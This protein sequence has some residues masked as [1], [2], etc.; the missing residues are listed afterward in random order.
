MS[1]SISHL[2]KPLLATAAVCVTFAAHCE[3][4]QVSGPATEP[5]AGCTAKDPANASAPG[6][7]PQPGAQA[8]QCEPQA[9]TA[10]QEARAYV[11]AT[12][13]PGTTMTMQGPELAVAR[14]NPEFVTR[15]ADAIR[16]AR[17]SGLP[18]AGIFSAYRPPGF[19]IGGFLD[20]YRSLHSYGLAV[21]MTGIGDP[22]SADTKHW[23]Q[24]AARHGV[25]CPY[26]IDSKSEWNH[27]QALPGKGVPAGGPLRKTINAQGPIDLA[28]MFKVGE[29]LIDDD[30]PKAIRLAEAIN[31][32][33]EPV[34]V[35][36]NSPSEGV[37]VAHAHHEH[38]AHHR[39]SQMATRHGRKTK[40]V[41]TAKN[42][43]KTKSVMVAK[44]ETRAVE[45][46][47]EKRAD[48][49][50]AHAVR[51]ATRD[52]DTSRRRSHVA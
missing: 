13:S 9:Q 17:Q 23:H 49:A 32:H 35:A 10:E 39:L 3:P 15:L 50:K 47:H 31:V 14:L 29:A 8:I 16:D 44:N 41:M 52:R 46:S 21:D 6:A 28:Q 26:S 42:G 51:K 38:E 24:I 36:S 18:N 7:D 1:R 22:G 2:V 40:S 34:R 4:A 20:K 11:L 12:S 30:L 33:Q 43:R 45:R 25:F 5:Q 27:C 37:H 48:E 19:G